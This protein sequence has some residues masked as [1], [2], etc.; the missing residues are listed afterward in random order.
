MTRATH[1][2]LSVVLGSILAAPLLAC[3]FSKQLDPDGIA[4]TG[5]TG[6]DGEMSGT[7][8]T[9]D[10]ASISSTSATATATATA[11]NTAGED[12]TV[13]ETT[14]TA[15]AHHP[16]CEAAA[17]SPLPEVPPINADGEGRPNFDLWRDLPCGAGGHLCGTAG[18]ASACESQFMC[19]Q[20]DPGVGGVCT[21]FDSDASCDGEGE[22]IGY[23]D[24]TC[25]MCAPIQAHADACCAALPGFDCRAWPYPADGTPGMVCAR[26]EDCEPGLVCGPSGGSMGYG[27]CQCPGLAAD[28]IQP[29][30]DCWF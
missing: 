17:P 14:G 15:G 16:A 25:W 6:D 26:H 27:I 24:G 13:G 19:L 23:G 1:S 28:G 20:T 2:H 12:T 8:G 7:T 3:E 9:S 21:Y 10:G 29:G 18:S 4:G 5:S 11:T 22:V 30:A